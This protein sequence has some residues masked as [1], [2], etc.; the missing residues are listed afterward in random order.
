MKA[1]AEDGTHEYA[2]MNERQQKIV[3]RMRVQQRKT[4]AKMLSEKGSD[5]LDA[6]LQ[7]LGDDENQI[8]LDTCLRRIRSAASE[9]RHLEKRGVRLGKKTAD[10]LKAIESSR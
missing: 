10:L 9:I 7:K 4:A 8:A 3:S 2:G 6:W 5:A 1:H